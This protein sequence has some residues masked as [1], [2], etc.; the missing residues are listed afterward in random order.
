MNRGA[1]QA[2]LKW[3]ERRDWRQWAELTEGTYI[4]RTNKSD[5]TDE[6]I[7]LTYVQLYQAEAAFRINKSELSIRPVWHQREDRVQAHILVCFLAFCLWKTLEGW[8]SQAGLGNSPR[9][10]LEEMAR[11]QCVDVVLPVKDGPEVRLRCVA[12]PDNAQRRPSGG[13]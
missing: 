6:E 11:I 13:R 5:W 12:R 7:W 10:L 9:T 1:A 2:V 8:Q 4:L 3:T